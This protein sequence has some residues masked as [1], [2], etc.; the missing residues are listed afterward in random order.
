[1]EYVDWVSPGQLPPIIYASH[2]IDSPGSVLLNGLS[3]GER[4]TSWFKVA[5][6]SS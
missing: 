2:L 6:G 1:M 4:K 5:S 3:C